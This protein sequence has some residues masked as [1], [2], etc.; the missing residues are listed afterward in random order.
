MLLDNTSTV[1]A[2]DFSAW[3]GLS[4]ELQGFSIQIRLVVGG[5]EYSPVDHEEVG[6]GSG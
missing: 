4:D 2:N 1:N 3:K 5:T 6:I